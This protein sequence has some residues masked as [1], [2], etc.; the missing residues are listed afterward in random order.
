MA[1]VQTP[2]QGPAPKE[3]PRKDEARREEQEKRA[4][5][6]ELRD[7]DAHEFYDS[8]L[9]WIEKEIPKPYRRS[10][11]I[12]PF[13]IKQV[14]WQPM[15]MT[16]NDTQELQKFSTMTAKLLSLLRSIDQKGLECPYI[17]QVNRPILDKAIEKCDR[18]KDASL[19][20]LQA[21]GF[22]AWLHHLFN[23]SHIRL[24]QRDLEYFKRRLDAI[25]MMC[26]HQEFAQ[27]LVRL[28]REVTYRTGNVLKDEDTSAP[29]A[30]SVPKKGRQLQDLM[31]FSKGFQ[32]V[33]A[34]AAK[35]EQPRSISGEG[36]SIQSPQQP[37]R[38]PSE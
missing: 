27:D 37:L 33:S 12:N 25:S 3:D 11:H 24:A 9:Q 21:K 31:G 30:K 13:R 8:L 17:H 5:E 23:G 1:A 34:Q 19:K 7:F 29:P 38:R 32:P 10:L 26:R 18:L 16:K 36:K 20:Y 35:A 14:L 28:R 2:P 6:V 4:L 22:Y 15:P